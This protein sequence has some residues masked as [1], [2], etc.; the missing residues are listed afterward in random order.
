MEHSS[1]ECVFATS[2]ERRWLVEQRL[3]SG[4]SLLGVLLAF[5]SYVLGSVSLVSSE[6]LLAVCCEGP[7]LMTTV[8]KAVVCQWIINMSLI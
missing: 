8:L 3:V 7:V 2:T 4:L 1:F 5:C 6:V